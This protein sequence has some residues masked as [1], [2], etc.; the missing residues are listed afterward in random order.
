M[1]CCCETGVVEDLV[2][3]HAQPLHDR[4]G[5]GVARVDHRDHLRHTRRRTRSRVCRAAA[6]TCP[7]PSCAQSRRQ[8]ILMSPLGPQSCGRGLGAGG[9]PVA[10]VLV[11]PWSW[12]EAVL[13]ASCRWRWRAVEFLV[14]GQLRRDLRRWNSTT[15]RSSKIRCQATASSSGG[16]AQP[17]NRR[18]LGSLG[19]PSTGVIGG[20]AGLSC[21][22]QCPIGTPIFEPRRSRRDRAP[23]RQHR[24]C[25]RAWARGQ[26]APR[27]RTTWPRPRL[28]R[29]PAGRPRVPREK[30]CGDEPDPARGQA[31]HRHGHRHLE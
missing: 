29:P 2:E 24:R 11:P 7:C 26:P 16:D 5:P 25:D 10:G 3:P 12:A 15:S 27:P 17:Y 9:H 23:L 20:D 8:P 6:V 28:R 14:D 1:P 4:D 22:V 31:A 13:G 30:V 21:L 19:S 18:K